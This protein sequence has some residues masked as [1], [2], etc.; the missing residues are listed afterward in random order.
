MPESRRPLTGSNQ[1][2]ALLGSRDQPTD[3]VRDYCYLLAEALEEKGR[4]LEL[5]QVEWAEQGWRRALKELDSELADRRDN[6]VLVQYTHLAWSRRGFPIRFP[7]LIQ[8]LKRRGMKALVVFHD[9]TP[10]GGRRLRDRLRRRVQLAVMRRASLL[11]DR[12]V[13]SISPGRVA[14]MRESRLH[15][16]I[17][18]VP[19]G[20]NIPA[21]CHGETI[22]RRDV[23]AV[24]V[25]GFTNFE[26]ETTLVASVMARVAE[27]CGPLCLIIFG[28]GAQNA[29]EM[30]RQRLNGRRVE[31]QAF[32][33]LPPE[34]AGSL[35][36]S[37]HVQLFVRLGVSARR[38]S[39]I[40]GI[41]SGLPVVGFADAETDFPIT[42]AGVR[43]VPL[44]DADGLVR[45]L[46]SV[47]RDDALRE[48]LRQR[49]HDASRRYF[50]WE[51][52]AEQ[53]LS[54]IDQP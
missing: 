21:H 5:V 49:S 27:S 3:A 39:A 38:G 8:R 14:W 46:T 31:L 2:I 32:G 54:V 24:V 29:E 20:S 23:P 19:V 40:A 48:M 43:L 42:E 1:L 26:A 37:A 15:D 35:L 52:I 36:A 10:F 51:S 41:S 4:S 53:Y 22:S 6:W 7:G 30:L 45:E 28:R 33:I 50:S 18:A 44:G 17:L 13:S 25:F 12:I 34:A 9:P 16:K 11:A 47:L